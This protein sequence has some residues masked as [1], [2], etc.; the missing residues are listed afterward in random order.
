[1]SRLS[2]PKRYE[3]VGCELLFCLLNPYKIPLE[4]VM[5]SIELLGK[6]V[7]PEFAD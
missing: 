4:E 2:L 1:L 7:I 6:H 3:A 5:H